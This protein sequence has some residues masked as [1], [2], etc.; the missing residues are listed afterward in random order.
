MT[1]DRLFDV[2]VTASERSC[3]LSTLSPR[4]PQIPVGWDHPLLWSSPR[5]ATCPMSLQPKT[6]SHLTNIHSPTDAVAVPK[7][8]A[9]KPVVGNV[10]VW[11]DV[12]TFTAN[13]PVTVPALSR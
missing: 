5:R 6:T 13:G 4:S 10:I 1:S 8:H 7:Y 12:F 3:V 2:S 11:S 9:E